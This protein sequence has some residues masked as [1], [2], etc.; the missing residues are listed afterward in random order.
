VSE[1]QRRL[2]IWAVGQSIHAP[3]LRDELIAVLKRVKCTPQEPL[4]KTGLGKP[5]PLGKAADTNERG[6]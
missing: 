6:E 5:K 2:I 1:E 3:A 4:G